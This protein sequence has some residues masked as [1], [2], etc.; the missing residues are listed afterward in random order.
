MN[1]AQRTLLWVG[2]LTALAASPPKF[3]IGLLVVVGVL[4]WAFDRWPQEK[5]RLALAPLVIAALLLLW[6]FREDWLW[7]LGG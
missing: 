2:G 7:I 1:R 6:K 4:F 3:A 5:Y